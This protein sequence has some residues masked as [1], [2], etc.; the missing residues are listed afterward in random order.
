MVRLDGLRLL[1]DVVKIRAVEAKKTRSVTA[2]N[3]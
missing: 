1:I 3:E 2:K